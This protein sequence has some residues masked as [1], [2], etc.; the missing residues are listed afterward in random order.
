[1]FPPKGGSIPSS[2]FITVFG[3]WF[4]LILSVSNFRSVICF[5]FNLPYIMLCLKEQHFKRFRYENEALCLQLNFV[6]LMPLAE[7]AGR[8][9]FYT[10]TFIYLT[11]VLP[12]NV[13]G[14][15]LH[16]WKKK[17]ACNLINL[18]QWCHS[19]TKLHFENLGTR[20]WKAAHYRNQ[21][22]DFFVPHI[23][24]SSENLVPVPLSDITGG[25]LE[26]QM[27][28][29][30]SEYMFCLNAKNHDLKCN[31]HWLEAIDCRGG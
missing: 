1:M 31:S 9:V 27:Y 23:L 29:I 14:V 5:S 12:I 22:Y 3:S 11:P 24:L 30:S 8:Q 26:A 17:A 13:W 20:F 28:C 19:V 16:K 2:F 10:F 21:R 6:S 7:L 4:L 15:V 25:K 18:L